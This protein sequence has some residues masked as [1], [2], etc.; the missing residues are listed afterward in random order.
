MQAPELP[1]TLR[2]DMRPVHSRCLAITNYRGKFLQADGVKDSSFRVAIFWVITACTLKLLFRYFWGKFL[3]RSCLKSI[4]PF[5]FVA[6]FDDSL[7]RTP[8]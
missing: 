6:L 2:I 5:S 4:P 7:F 1:G 3:R 8:L